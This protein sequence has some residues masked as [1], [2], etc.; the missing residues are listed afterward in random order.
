MTYR[1]KM[2][3]GQVVFEGGI[4]PADGVELR[5]EVEPTASEVATAPVQPKQ[6]ETL[7]ELLLSF[8][9]VVT[10]PSLPADSSVNLDHYLYGT[11][12]R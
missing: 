2:E 4:K 3:N 6:Q 1:A 9:G 5:V 8:A 12:K 7:S 10:D 11:P